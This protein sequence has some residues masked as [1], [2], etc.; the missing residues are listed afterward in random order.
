MS[1]SA[2]ANSPLSAHDFSGQPRSEEPVVKYDFED[3][4]YRVFIDTLGYLPPE[5]ITLVCAAYRFSDEAALQV[6]IAAALTARSRSIGGK[7]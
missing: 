7:R 4:A 1:Y 6:G 2:P 3:P 5:E